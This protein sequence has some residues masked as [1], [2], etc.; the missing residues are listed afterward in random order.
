M[1]NG[2]S[3]VANSFFTWKRPS[4]TKDTTDRDNVGAERDAPQH[5]ET[6]VEKSVTN[7]AQQGFNEQKR[8]DAGSQADKVDVAQVQDNV[9]SDIGRPHVDNDDTR[10]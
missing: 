1:Y 7:A 4:V 3:L 5:I 6:S 2:L 10:R 8:E 9:S